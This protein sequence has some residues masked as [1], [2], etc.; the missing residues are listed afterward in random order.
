M[1]SAREKVLITASAR[2]TS[3]SST[4]RAV[5]IRSRSGSSFE[6]VSF[7]TLMGRMTAAMPIKS[8]TLM[9]LLPMTLPIRISVLPLIKDEKDTANSGAPVP[10]ATIVRPMRSL[11]TLKLEATDEAPSTSQSAPLISKM[12]PIIRIKT[13]NIISMMLMIISHF[14]LHKNGASEETLTLDLF[15]GKEAL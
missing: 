14:C 5:E 1:A 9:I 15:L 6:T 4:I 11:L 10:K 7:L 3:R 8:R 2:L 12:K 13:C